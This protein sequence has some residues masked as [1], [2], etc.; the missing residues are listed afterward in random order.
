MSDVNGWKNHETWLTNLHLGD[1][2]IMDLDTFL[3]HTGYRL[4][5]SKGQNSGDV[6]ANLAE[7]IR[8][9]VQEM[10]IDPIPKTGF[11]VFL[12]DIVA[13]AI[14]CV[15]YREIAENFIEMNDTVLTST[16]EDD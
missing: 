1:M 4:N 7:L 8:D 3:F 2:G 12:T 9:F 14:S 11:N 16:G 10:L 15:D 5:T 6:V 13:N